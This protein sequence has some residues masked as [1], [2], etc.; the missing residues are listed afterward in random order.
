MLVDQIMRVVA[1][2]DT[3]TRQS[4]QFSS[5]MLTIVVLLGLLVLAN[6][7]WP[8]YLLIPI[9]ALVIL[10]KP[11]NRKR[12]FELIED[13]FGLEEG[14]ELKKSHLN[15]LFWPAL[16]GIIGLRIALALM[17]QTAFII[18]IALFHI[19]FIYVQSKLM[20]PLVLDFLLFGVVTLVM[21]RALL[22]AVALAAIITFA[23]IVLQRTYFEQ[24]LAAL[25][26]HVVAAFFVYWL[27]ASLSAM[28][29]A[30][31]GMLLAVVVVAIFPVFVLGI[32]S[33]RT[34]LAFIV[35][36]VF[37]TALLVLM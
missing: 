19:V 23:G 1:V 2:D 28:T 14:T 3:Q 22:S 6:V 12:V 24:Q 17:P 25:A 5:V 20:L 27:A 7:F 21:E 10:W 37:T 31:L 33:P 26:F 13:T 15:R 8:A 16:F 35:K 32:G 29:A 9:A 18:G 36:V 11:V 30:V 4:G 34:L